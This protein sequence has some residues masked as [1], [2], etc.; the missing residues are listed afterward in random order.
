MGSLILRA[1][2]QAYPDPENS[3]EHSTHSLVQGSGT[4]GATLLEDE[5]P[6]G[7]AFP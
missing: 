5:N 4:P 3:G 6:H 1:I 2:E 7:L